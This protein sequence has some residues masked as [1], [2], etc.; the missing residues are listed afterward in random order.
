MQARRGSVPEIA[1]SVAKWL[2]ICLAPVSLGVAFFLPVYT[3]ELVW[4]VIQARMHLDDMRN[5][6]AHISCER[7]PVPIPTLLVPARLV[8]ALLYGNMDDPLHLRMTGAAFGVAIIGAAWLVLDRAVGRR[9]GRANLTAIV[10][11]LATVGVMPFL[12]VINRP[13]QII[14]LAII[15]LGIH[16]SSA[17][18]RRVDRPWRTS[19][20]RRL[21]SRSWGW[22]LRPIPGGFSSCR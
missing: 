15:L 10:L 19:P 17:R 13:E 21:R 22:S 3:D 18:H 11:A 4:K 5:V 14:A 16:S 9:V 12:L 2:V 20:R 8:D 6:V 1:V 7:P